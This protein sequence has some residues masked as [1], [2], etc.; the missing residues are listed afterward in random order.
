MGPYFNSL[1]NAGLPVGFSAA[2]GE[3]LAPPSAG[4]RAGPVLIE[5]SSG[6]PACTVSPSAPN[7]HTQCVPGAPGRS[8]PTLGVLTC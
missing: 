7:T 3:P 5:P 1:H 8:A 4:H 6:A 2:N